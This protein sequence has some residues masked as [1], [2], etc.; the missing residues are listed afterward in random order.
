MAIQ[1]VCDGE[2]ILAVGQK[3]FYRNRYSTG[4]TENNK[5]NII[6]NTINYTRNR[7]RIFS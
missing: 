7:G 3:V 5:N 1:L 4:R 2:M 6:E